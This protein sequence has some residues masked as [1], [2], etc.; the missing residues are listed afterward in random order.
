MQDIKTKEFSRNSNQ[1]NLMKAVIFTKSG[2]PDVLEIKKIEKPIPK[3]DEILVKVH[4]TAVNSGDIN[5]RSFK[6][7]FLFW[8]LMR[9]LYGLKKPKRLILGSA[10]SGEIESVGKDVTRFKKGDQVFASTG[11]NFGANAEYVV[12]PERG[13]IALKPTNLS[14]EEAAAVPFG[15]LTAL[16]YLRQ[17]NIQEGQ[18]ILINGASGS[19]GTFAIQLAKYF[20]AEVVGVCSTKNLELVKS[21]GIDKVIDYKKEDFTESKEHYDLIFDVAGK[22]S[23]SDCQ[24]VLASD[25]IFVSTKKGLAKENAEDLKFLKDLIEAGNIRSIID[26]TFPLDEIVEAHNY[27]ET[28][29]KA[30][31]VI[32]TI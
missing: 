8:L 32:I 26:R 16:Y 24:K 1:D 9:I 10:L 22:S 6:S 29:K 17:G 21:L 12:I 5:L 30:G 14:Y 7:Q 23:Q 4:A 3:D 19:V 15:A 20:G 31:N 13:V 2:P 27:A 28:G 25:G 11:M 18:K